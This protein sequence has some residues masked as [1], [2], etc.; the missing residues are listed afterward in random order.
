METLIVFCVFSRVQMYTKKL[1][2]VATFLIWV[3]LSA[4]LHIMATWK[5]IPPPLEIFKI[6]PCFFNTFF[7]SHKGLYK[8]G[9]Q[10]KDSFPLFTSISLSP[11]PPLLSKFFPVFNSPL[12]PGGTVRIYIPASDLVTKPCIWVLC[13][14]IKIAVFCIIV[15]YY[16]I[17]F[18]KIAW[19][20]GRYPLFFLLFFGAA[21]A[22]VFSSG[23]GS[24]TLIF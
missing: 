20:A 4:G 19:E 11:F 21:T 23:S 8:T 24:P 2:K 7:G 22:P 10:N 3:Y 5:N 17:F 6:L 16:C 13:V 14:I 1:A 12:P 15:R 18:C 9:K